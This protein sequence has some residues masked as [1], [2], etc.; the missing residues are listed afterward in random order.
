MKILNHIF[1]VILRG[2]HPKAQTGQ[3][4][5]CNINSVLED[6]GYTSEYSGK[7]AIIESNHLIDYVGIAYTELWLARNYIDYN[8]NNLFKSD[9]A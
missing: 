8:T 9:L 7:W 2:A 4:V 1:K 5:E 3:V 6:R